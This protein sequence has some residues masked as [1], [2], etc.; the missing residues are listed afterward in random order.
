MDDPDVSD[1]ELLD[2]LAAAAFAA[3]PDVELIEADE[4]IEGDAEHGVNHESELG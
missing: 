1:A 3:D 2:G 4:A